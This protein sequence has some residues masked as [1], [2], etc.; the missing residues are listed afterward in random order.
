MAVHVTRAGVALTVGIIVLT[1]LIIGG[2]FWAKGSGEQAR[3]EDAIAIAEQNL[4][5]ESNEE[6]VLNDGAAPEENANQG[7][8]Q[9]TEQEAT[10]ESTQSTNI[11]QGSTVDEL[12]QTGPSD[13]LNLIVMGV[14]V[15]LGTSYYQSR[16]TSNKAV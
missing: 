16:R 3:R 10:P 9:A 4:E 15:F 1:G 8:G 13:N 6:I 11:P 12:P 14:V 7:V 5:N 2:L